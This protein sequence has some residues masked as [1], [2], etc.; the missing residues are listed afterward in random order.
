MKSGVYALLRLDRAPLPRPDCALMGLAEEAGANA[1]QAASLLIK[2]VDG[3]PDGGAVSTV[4]TG[5][6]SV[7]LVGH[8]SDPS[9]LEKTYCLPPASPPA[10]IADHV[11]RRHGAE[12]ALH[13]VGEWTLLRW[14][15]A[16]RLMTVT[17]SDAYRDSIYYACDGRTA[18]VAPSVMQLARLPWVGGGI[19][20]RGFPLHLATAPLRRY[21]ID[22]SSVAGVRRI[23]PG[24]T[25]TFGSIRRSTSCGAPELPERWRGRFEDALE[26]FDGLLDAIL[27]GQLEDHRSIAVMVSGGLDSSIVAW[28]AHRARKAEQPLAFYASVAP[29]ASGLADQWA[30]GKLVAERLNVPL[31]PVCP[32]A[33][34]SAYIPS[35]RTFA[36]SELPI[37]SPRHYLYDAFYDRVASDGADLLLDGAYGEY[38]ITYPIALHDPVPTMRQLVRRLRLRVWHWRNRPLGVADL[39]HARLSR[40]ALERLPGEWRN[41]AGAA[42]PHA[43]VRSRGQQ[44]GFMAAMSKNRMTP[45]STPV[46]TLRHCYPLRDRRLVRLMAA[47]PAGFIEQGGLNRSIARH[48]LLRRLPDEIALRRTGGAFSPDFEVRLLGQADHALDALPAWRA[49]EAAD[50]LDLGWL[51]RQCLKIRQGGSPGLHTLFRVQATASTAQYLLWKREILGR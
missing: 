27:A 3:G 1:A 31:V 47:M 26:A 2:G 18:A 43:E 14:C 39:F 46:P 34:A 11:W 15:P 16:E 17:V 49:S 24:G 5:G 45:T 32:P 21:L 51:E 25:E 6:V 12:I 9:G 36:H 29:P 40:A 35:R 19:D 33:S 42:Y 13:L 4:E 28:Y 30:Y 23:P 44:W 22:E 10:L 50:W 48:L 38:T 8:L 37:A 20:E 7:V 41:L